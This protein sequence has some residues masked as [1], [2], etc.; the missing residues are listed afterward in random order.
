MTDQERDNYHGALAAL[1]NIASFEPRQENSTHGPRL[2]CQHC[3]HAWVID[4]E[5]PHHAGHC[6][7]VTAR[8][9]LGVAPSHPPSTEGCA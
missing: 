2:R 1:Q 5:A 9:A 8:T 4:K 6:A 7:W 3:G